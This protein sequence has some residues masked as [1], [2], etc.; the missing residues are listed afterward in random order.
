M[1]LV[2]CIAQ[3]RRHHEL[4]RVE[5]GLVVFVVGEEQIVRASLGV[6]RNAPI[7]GFGDGG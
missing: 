2:S 3:W 4:G 1:P 6:N 7:A 5:S